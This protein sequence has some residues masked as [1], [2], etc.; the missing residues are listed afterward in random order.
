M[1]YRDILYSVAIL[2][3]I[4]WKISNILDFKATIPFVKGGSKHEFVTG[5]IVPKQVK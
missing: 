2:R 3:E 5:F 4:I 1:C